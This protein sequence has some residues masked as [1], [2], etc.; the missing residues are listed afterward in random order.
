MLNYRNFKN[1]QRFLIDL[2]RRGY[3]KEIFEI[4]D[5]TS[6]VFN[7]KVWELHIRY[8]LGNSIYEIKKTLFH[9]MELQ[10][11]WVLSLDKRGRTTEKFYIKEYE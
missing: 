6:E 2:R 5:V 3:K 7:G 1:L 11:C 9:Y 10:G 4:R 8:S